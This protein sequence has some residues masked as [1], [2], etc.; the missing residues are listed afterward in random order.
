M[1]AI[2]VWLTF[3][4]PDVPFANHAASGRC[5]TPAGCRWRLRP[6]N[7][8][9]RGGHG[10]TAAHAPDF[11]GTGRIGSRRGKWRFGYPDITGRDSALL[12]DLNYRERMPLFGVRT[13]SSA[14]LGR[15]VA[16]D[17]PMLDGHAGERIQV[18]QDVYV[19]FLICRGP[20]RVEAD[21]TYVLSLSRSVGVAG[22]ESLE[23][24]LQSR[25]AFP[26]VAYVAA[27]LPEESQYPDNAS[28]RYPV[29][30]YRHH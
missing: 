29:C 5:A 1:G 9:G 11:R 16:M 7:G 21:K 4:S 26:Q 20:H 15:H 23:Q 6:G 14:P 10:K 18:P 22:S 8:G 19:R 17:V 24:P 27:Q 25:H 30:R 2:L 12:I 28:Q 3:R 13:L